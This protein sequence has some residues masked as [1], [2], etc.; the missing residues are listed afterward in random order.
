VTGLLVVVG[1]PIGNLGDLS[2]RAHDALAGADL[3]CCEDTRHTRKLL[4]HAGISGV[5]LAALHEHNE[6][7]MAQ[8]IVAQVAGGA[9][10]ALVSDAGMPGIS[11]PGQ[12]VVAAVTQSGLALT[13]IPGPSAA[14][15]ALVGSGMDSGRFCFEGFLPRKGRER[16]DRLAEIAGEAR[17][18]VLYEAPHRVARTLADLSQVCGPHRQVAV[19]RE[20]T[21]LHEQRWSGTLQEAVAWVANAPIKGEWVLLVAGAVSEPVD[22]TDAALAAALAVRWELGDD[23]RVAVAE[24]AAAHRV[25]KRRVYQLA[26]DLAQRPGSPGRPGSA[27]SA[28]SPGSPGR[29]KTAEWGGAGP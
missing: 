3:I 24:V 23:R 12:R 11:D 13:V 14:L 1:T 5:A 9:T 17:T 25:P 28:G 7:E 2:P 26:L 15:V 16:G 19:G 6:A 18:V 20:L 29:P 21:K 4:T 8:R 10:V 27:G 22:V